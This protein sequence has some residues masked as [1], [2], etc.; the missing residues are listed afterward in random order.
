MQEE[1]EDKTGWSLS[2]GEYA[3]THLL[4]LLALLSW[5]DCV[6]SDTQQITNSRKLSYGLF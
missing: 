2:L 6:T 1:E 5:L 4:V 3:F